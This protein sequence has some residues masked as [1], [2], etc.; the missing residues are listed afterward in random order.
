MCLG[1]VTTTSDPGP[2]L[3]PMSTLGPRFLG[4]GALDLDSFFGSEDAGGCG[5][6]RALSGA[7][8]SAGFGFCSS[9]MVKNKS[10]TDFCKWVPYVSLYR[11]SQAAKLGYQSTLD[12]P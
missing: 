1:G 4:G 2:I 8:S 3:G 7:F 9:F 5:L 11:V 6:E 10:E 12:Q